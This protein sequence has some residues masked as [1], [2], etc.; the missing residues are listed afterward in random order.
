MT[1]WKN[2]TV[3]VQELWLHKMLSS[4]KRASVAKLGL[5]LNKDGSF[6]LQHSRRMQTVSK[7][8]SHGIPHQRPQGDEMDNNFPH[9]IINH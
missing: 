3:S 5:T 7:P 2:P 9:C 4:S 6:M 8:S 1:Y